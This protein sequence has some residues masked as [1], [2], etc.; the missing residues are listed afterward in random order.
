MTDNDRI[1]DLYVIWRYDAGDLQVQ[2]N[3]VIAGDEVPAD[4]KRSIQLGATGP[5]ADSR[6]RHIA[7][8]LLNQLGSRIRPDDDFTLPGGE[9]IK[10]EI[11]RL[12][13]MHGRHDEY[14][15]VEYELQRSIGTTTKATAKIRYSD[16]T[17]FQRNE[18][19]EL[20]RVARRE[21]FGRLAGL[22]SG[23]EIDPKRFKAEKV[24]V[25]ISYRESGSLAAEALFDGL[26]EYDNR[27]V[28]RPWYDKIDMQAG[29]WIKQLEDAIHE[30]DIFVA[31]LTAD[32]RDGPVA[33]RELDQA[34]REWMADPDRRIIPILIEGEPNDYVGT[35]L[36]GLNM[37]I[38]RDGITGDIIEQVAH[39]AL[40]VSRN[41]YAS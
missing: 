24:G 28:F 6:A 17:D 8:T 38:A 7:E 2:V 31:V 4:V 35:F 15:V 9:P 21:A 27:G 20:Y 3:K 26:G 22:F 41:P 25:F 40:G 13:R 11:S 32:Y 16:L 37:V 36:G 23:G 18:A 33:V 10:S 5:I 19:E 39:D 12:I 29:P 14:V 30:Y 1:L 34:M